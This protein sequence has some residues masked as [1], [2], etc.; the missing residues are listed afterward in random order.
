MESKYAKQFK[1]GVLELVILKKLSKR[2]MYGYQIITEMDRTGNVF[3]LKEGTLYP[4]LY[5]LEDDGM[6]ET[7]WEQAEDRS[8]PKKYYAITEKGSYTLE[9]VSKQWFDFTKAVE[10]ILKE[11]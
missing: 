3:N 9:E 2:E 11:D 6:L 1:K 8:V 7:R 4:L 10:Q 5:R